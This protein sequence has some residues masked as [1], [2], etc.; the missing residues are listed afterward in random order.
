[1]PRIA[2]KTIKEHRENIETA[3]VDAAED[4]LRNEPEGKLTA[5]AIAK[6]AGIARNSIY[7]YV[8]S[9][10]D[11]RGMVIKRYMPRWMKAVAEATADITDPREWLAAWIAANLR[12]AATSSHGWLRNIVVAADNAHNPEKPRT[13]S[14]DNRS[15]FTKAGVDV[16]E[17]HEHANA[18]LRETWEELVS[19]NPDIYVALT[20]AQLGVGFR[21]V[22][23]GAPVEEVIDTITQVILGMVDTATGNTSA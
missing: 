20:M 15:T 16:D 5:S 10:D 7:R 12:Q 14:I 1:M 8:K 2:A 23:D 17:V 18:H 22:D 3:L 21:A 6:R 19:D 13:A 9:V 11:L 4:I